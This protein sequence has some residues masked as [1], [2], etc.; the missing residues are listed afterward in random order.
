MVNRSLIAFFAPPF[1]NVG[2]LDEIIINLKGVNYMPQISI[3][4]S[5]MSDLDQ[6]MEIVDDARALLKKDGSPQWQDGHPD[7]QMFADGIANHVSWLLTMGN[8][9][10]GVAAL[11]LTAEPTYA[12]IKNGSWKAVNEPYATIHR[13][14]ISSHFRGRHL[15]KYFL[16]GLLSIGRGQGFRNFRLDTYPKNIRVQYLAESLGFVKRGD[17]LVKDNIDPRRVAFELNINV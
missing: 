15:S 1:Y 8:D 9:I 14:A 11:Q 12:E 7:R 3:R 6:I 2:N 17:I 10:V 4:R 13:L 16:V 5:E